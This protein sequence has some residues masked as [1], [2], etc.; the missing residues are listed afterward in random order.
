MAGQM[1]FRHRMSTRVWHWINAT[2]MVV[3]FM[4][5]LMVFNAHPRLYWGHFG[6]SHDPAWLELPRFPGWATI[7]TDYSLALGRLWHFGF[8]WIFAFGFLAYLMWSLFNGH[9]RKDVALS[10]TEVAPSNLWHDIKKHAR[11]DFHSDDTRYNPLQKITYSLVLFGL[12]PLLIMTGLTMSP[13]MNAA[14]PWLV[15][16]F[17]GRQSARSLHFIAAF[18]MLA[19]FFVH[20]A[21]VM[22]AGP[23]NEVRSMITGYF[24]LPDPKA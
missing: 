23:I 22:L 16:L 15:D 14:M 4:S 12:I 13:G 19:F 9:W 1:I 11:L 3:M 18:G 20:I 21:L 17:G 6:S 10:R 8:A 7:P 5:G 24:R 2:V